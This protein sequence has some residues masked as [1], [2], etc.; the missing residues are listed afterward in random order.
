MTTWQRKYPKRILGPGAASGCGSH[1]GYRWAPPWE[2][3]IRVKKYAG[4]SGR[5]VQGLGSEHFLTC[6]PVATPSFEATLLFIYFFN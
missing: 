1:T 6:F 4:G 3:S 5:E 2:P